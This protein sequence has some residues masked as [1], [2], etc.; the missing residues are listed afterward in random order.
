MQ[1]LG[2]FQGSG[3]PL[4]LICLWLGVTA[5]VPVHAQILEEPAAEAPA[6]EPAPDPY[7]RETP[8]STVTGLIRALGDQD[9]N[10][11]GNYFYLSMDGEGQEAEAADF[12]RQLQAALDRGGTLDP[13]AALANEPAGRIEDGLDA[14][15]ES[16]GSFP[17]EDAPP[18]VLVR[19]ENAE[20]VQLWRI[21]D[22]TREW[23]DRDEPAPEIAA[24]ERAAEATLVAGA[25]LKDWLILMGLA[26]ISFA[27]FRLIAAGLLAA[28]RIFSRDPSRSG[29]FRFIQAALPPFSLFAA[30]VC[31]QLWANAIPV[32]IVARQ[33][34][35]RYAGIVAWFALIWFALRLVDAI[36]QVSAARMQRSERRQAV[37]V[38]TL[39]RRT[40]KVLLLAVAVV[41]ILDTL[42]VDV[43]TGVAALGIGGI[44]LALG[45]QKTVENLV[46][47]VTLIADKPVQVGDFCRVGDVVG[48]VED[49]GMRSTR[50][51]TNDRTV[52]TIPNGD[53]SSRQIENYAKRDRFLFNPRIGVEYGIGPAKLK[54]AVDLIE[55]VLRDHP[56]VDD[57]GVR[58]RFADFG[59]SS[60]DIDI[61]SYIGV[62]DF[63]D[64]LKVRQELLLTIF[65]RLEAADIGIAFPTRTLHLV[66]DPEAQA[67]RSEPREA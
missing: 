33:T 16:V 6:A 1:V 52:V 30:V 34:L 24:E 47:S 4:L 38:I 55:T 37:S 58:A 50:I 9:Y 49:I 43:T 59:A 25:P 14:Q 10:R 39:L 18:I 17:E 64:S 67:P 41:A 36:A 15:F 11:A 23:V 40:V 27:G 66:A 35:L 53:F 21:S 29:L 62:G 65:E 28:I 20:G 26:A 51:R 12:A 61:W 32:S 44:A 45:A 57:D 8:R 42:G 46:G 60:L 48:T 22:E 31:F 63:A 19:E 3:L 7:G 54:E 5:A 2:R 13:F 56:L